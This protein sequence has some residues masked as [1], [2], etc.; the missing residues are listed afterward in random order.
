MKSAIKKL[1]MITAYAILLVTITLSASTFS[2]TNPAHA[3]SLLDRIK[4]FVIRQSSATEPA[5]SPVANATLQRIISR[6]DGEINRRLATLANLN[7]II[8]TSTHLTSADKVSLQTEVNSTIS[9]L[10][11]LKSKLDAE[12]TI[13][14]ARNDT[15]SIATEYR[16]FAL[17]MPKI[18]L[19]KVADDI[20]STDSQ[21]ETLSSKL[22][23]RITS[24]QSSGK[25]V[26]TLQKELPDLNAKIAAAQNIAGNAEAK[27]IMLE[28]TDYNTDHHVLNDY[29]TQ[30]KTAKGDN[31]AAYADAKTMTSQLKSL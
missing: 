13:A 18:H 20:Q 14:N 2:I 26:S 30:L 31:L 11:T 3:E 27:V 9:N 23:T 4:Q 19:I 29:S 22:Q 7:G 6:G 21:L 25:D 8:N 17:V 16:V 24:A 12:T 5:K 28:P 15:K 10:T 1:S